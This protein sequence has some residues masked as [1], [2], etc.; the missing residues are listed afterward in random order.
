M[1]NDATVSYRKIT[2]KYGYFFL[3]GFVDSNETKVKTKER[4]VHFIRQSC[5]KAQ[6]LRSGFLPRLSVC[7][8]FS[9]SAAIAWK[10]RVS[11]INILQRNKAS[12]LDIETKERLISYA[13]SLTTEDYRSFSS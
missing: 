5:L 4:R 12:S 13:T 2:G 10:P 8:R 11:K 9:V 1:I 7:S 6:A 3:L